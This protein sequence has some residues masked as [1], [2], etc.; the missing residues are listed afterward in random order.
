MTDYVDI[1]DY[2]AAQD[3]LGSLWL[4]FEECLL[5]EQAIVFNTAYNL[6]SVTLKENA[7]PPLLTTI[8]SDNNIDTPTRI[9]TV[10]R[11]LIEGMVEL[12]CEMGIIIDKDY[13]TLDSMQELCNILNV[14][15]STDEIEDV[16]G[17]IDILDNETYDNKEKLITVIKRW[18]DLDDD[19][20][21]QYLIDD[22]SGETIKGLYI[23]LGV[24]TIDDADYINP[25]VA[26]RIKANKTFLGGT[27]AGSHV[28]NGGGIGMSFEVLS[29]LFINE[30]GICLANDKKQYLNEIMG[31]LLIS[32]QTNNE[33]QSGYEALIKDFAEGLDEIYM[34]S[35]V[36]EGITL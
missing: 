8:L 15:Y 3:D 28:L 4:N 10:R 27:L 19:G 14:M 7:L 36:L 31:L 34:G 33:I 21:M 22:V 20:D 12:L 32:S 23:G 30:L 9:N 26:K 13:V 5:V 29:N 17:L 24:L 35:K 18:L 11:T 2:K 6:I 25:D 1:T 16:L